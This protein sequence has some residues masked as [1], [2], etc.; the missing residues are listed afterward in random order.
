[1]RKLGR[2]GVQTHTTDLF[3]SQQGK[4]IDNVDTQIQGTPPRWAIILINPHNLKKFPIPLFYLLS[5]LLPLLTETQ[6]EE[7]STCEITTKTTGTK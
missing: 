7:N 2:R 5:L 1:L 4:V 3:S 6:Q